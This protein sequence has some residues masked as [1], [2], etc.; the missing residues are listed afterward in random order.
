MPTWHLAPY[1]RISA[2]ISAFV[3]A[4]GRRSKFLRSEKEAKTSI[5]R[6]RTSAERISFDSVPRRANCPLTP[7]SGPWGKTGVDITM[8]NPL[9][10][11]GLPPPPRL[12]PQQR[13][14]MKH[15]KRGKTLINLLLFPRLHV[16][17]ISRTSFHSTSSIVNYSNSLTSP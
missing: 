8:E 15:A 7:Q 17:H 12:L 13:Q 3:S 2:Q 16:Q 4:V 14:A 1:Q 9:G 10:C 5:A 11:H 6:P